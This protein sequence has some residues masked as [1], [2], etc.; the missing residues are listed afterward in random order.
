[1]NFLYVSSTFRGK[2]A[3]SVLLLEG[4]E[5]SN[6]AALETL[7][8]AFH[9]IMQH[10]VETGRAPHYSDLAAEMR[11]SVEAGRLLLHELMA[12]GI[13]AWVYPGTN[14]I[15]SLAPFHSLPNQYRL[16]VDG[17]QKWFGQ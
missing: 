9:Y 3:Y 12:T 8:R 16:T 4:E 13:P 5:K 11:L 14:D 7:D 6:M 15:V 1:L 2:G 10:F 17:Q